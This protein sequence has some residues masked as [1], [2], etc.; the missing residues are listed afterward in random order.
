PSMNL[1]RWKALPA[2]IQKAFID[3]SAPAMEFAA[4]LHDDYDRKAIAELNKYIKEVYYLPEEEMMRWKAAV[5]P[6]YDKLL[7][8]GTPFTKKQLEVLK[9][10]PK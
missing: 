5:Q 1:D 3:A 8:G 9:R 4:K 6:M 10:M 2:D 7:T